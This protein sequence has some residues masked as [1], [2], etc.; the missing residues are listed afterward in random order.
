M[1]LLDRGATELGLGLT[2]QQLEQFEIYYRELAD[3]NRRVNLTAITEYWEVQI[4]HFLDSLSVYLAFPRGPTSC[5]RLVDVGAGGG[6]PGLPLKLA[7][8][9]IQ[10]V[11]VESVGKKTRFLDH[12]VMVLGLSGVDVQNGRAEQLAHQSG[13]RERFHLAVSRGVAKL[14]TLLEYT[15]P[16][17]RVGG[18]VALLKRGVEEELA[19]ATAALD[20]LGGRLGDIYPVP[21]PGLND[22][23]VI[24][25]VEKVE[26]TPD[27]YPRRPG[28]PAK[29]P[30]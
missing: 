18:Q 24:V 10:L 27:R 19:G 3:W 11:L 2:A 9:D 17:C 23:R 14:P 26:A 21:V 16:F 20:A 1:E 4:K 25:S 12:L 6:F 7:L 13:L 28:L 29:R 8:P 15:L 22:G 5:I 30:L